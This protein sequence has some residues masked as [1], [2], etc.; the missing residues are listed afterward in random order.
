[1]PE[2]SGTAAKEQHCVKGHI[3]IGLIGTTIPSESA[4]T[5]IKPG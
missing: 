4:F 1:M 3:T 5:G 2:I